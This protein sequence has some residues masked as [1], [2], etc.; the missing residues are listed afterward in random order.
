M[1][2]SPL[3]QY[4]LLGVLGF[5]GYQLAQ[6]GAFGVKAKGWVGN[7]RVGFRTA[8]AGAGQ[9]QSSGTTSGSPATQAP[10]PPQSQQQPSSTT[11]IRDN[12]RDNNSGPTGYQFPSVVALFVAQYG[13]DPSDHSSA[14]VNYYRQQY[15]SWPDEDLVSGNADS[16]G[17]FDYAQSAIGYLQSIGAA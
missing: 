11:A 6:Q 14:W 16:A 9:S 1:A 8:G 5:A 7:F 13:L 12:I 3:L 17:L 4:G 10:A 2:R 15:G